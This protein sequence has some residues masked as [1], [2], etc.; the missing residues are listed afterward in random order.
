[1]DRAAESAGPAATLTQ[2][3]P[4]SG[5]NVLVFPTSRLLTS[6]MKPAAIFKAVLAFLFILFLAY[7]WY[8]WDM[9]S[10]FAPA[11]IEEILKQIGPFAPLIYMVIM[12]ATAII[13]PIPGPPLFVVA[14][15]LFGPF[16]GTVY[17]VVGSLA[18]AVVAFLIARF[19]GR[20]FIESMVGKQVVICCECSE[21]LLTK[22]VFFS[23]LL[24]LISFD[25]VSYGAGLTRMPLRSFVLATL[26]GSLPMTFIYH[27]F[28]SVIAV[29][30]TTALV[31]GLLIVAILFALPY[32]ADRWDIKRF[33]PRL[34][35]RNADDSCDPPDKKD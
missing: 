22:I 16:L 14:G 10:F 9:A 23:R 28:G 18:G 20:D 27:S 13:I 32:L 2:G 34:V 19:L 31:L 30:T 35:T 8:R 21:G 4:L 24:P 3:G 5:K 25:V 26:L 29:S 7:S 6:I 33:R 11:L 12:A 15:A 17:A 1:M